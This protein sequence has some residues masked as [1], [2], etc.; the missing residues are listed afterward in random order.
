MLER[1]VLDMLLWWTS[2]TI[3]KYIDAGVAIVSKYEVGILRKY[4][5]QRICFSTIA[6]LFDIEDPDFR[7]QN[8][9]RGLQV[10]GSQ[11]LG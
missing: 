3:S 7:K 9:V 2:R 11:I 5:Y 1:V 10:E 6:G 8:K 4:G